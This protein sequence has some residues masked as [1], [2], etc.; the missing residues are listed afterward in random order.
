LKQP[1]FDRKE[2][3]DESAGASDRGV[4]DRADKNTVHS[5]VHDWRDLVV[6]IQSESDPDKMIELVRQ[7]VDL[8]DEE[9]LRQNSRR[10]EK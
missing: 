4:G 8:Y 10:G 6:L 5:A 7:L 3:R 9:K 1:A 2:P